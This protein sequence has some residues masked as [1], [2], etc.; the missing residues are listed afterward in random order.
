MRIIKKIDTPTKAGE[1]FPPRLPL[2]LTIIDSMTIM[3]SLASSTLIK[4]L[5]MLIT[6][7]CSPS[8]LTPLIVS[9]VF[10]QHACLLHGIVDSQCAYS[11]RMCVL[12]IVML[13]NV[14][15]KEVYYHLF[16]SV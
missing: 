6:G 9:L 14:C 3:F 5:T 7:C 15:D 8:L 16:F 11:G 10:V 2:A 12:T 13:T 4:L 1:N